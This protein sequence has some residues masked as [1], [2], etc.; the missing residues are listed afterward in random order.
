M[1]QTT[2]PKH[3]CGICG[4]KF[5]WPGIMGSDPRRRVEAPTGRAMEIEQKGPAIH[6]E[7][8]VVTLMVS[9]KGGA[10]S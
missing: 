2:S 8:A 1:T 7:R 6:L 10:Q 5:S 9:F 4:F 3:I